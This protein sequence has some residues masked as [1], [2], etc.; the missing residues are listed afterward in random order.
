MIYGLAW[1]CADEN[2][3][4]YGHRL[5]YFPEG[6]DSPE[7]QEIKKK[8]DANCRSSFRVNH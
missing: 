4:S 1:D 7:K 6:V 3:S 2:F 8:V 5:T